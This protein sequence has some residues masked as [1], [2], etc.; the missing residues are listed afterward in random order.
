MAQKHGVST[1]QVTK[2]STPAEAA[3][4]PMV[5]L[6]T[7]GRWPSWTLGQALACSSPPLPGSAAATPAW[8]TR[9]ASMLRHSQADSLEGGTGGVR[10]V[11]YGVGSAIDCV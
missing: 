8:T 2:G 3:W 4:R 10:G 9:A 1:R 5:L 11:S 7:P 6:A